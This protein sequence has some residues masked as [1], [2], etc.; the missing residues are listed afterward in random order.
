MEQIQNLE[1]IYNENPELDSLN[2]EY[3]S[4][5]DLT[6]L[7]PILSKFSE[8]K[9]LSL[10]GNRLKNLPQDISV[11]ENLE[12]LDLSSN[13]ISNY[14]NIVSSL[15]SLP[16]LANLNITL[17][18]QEDE[19]LFIQNLPNLYMLN[20]RPVRED[21]NQEQEEDGDEQ[22]QQ[23]QQ[24]QYN[25]GEQE[26]E[27]YNYE[28]QNQSQNQYGNYQQQQNES[29]NYQQQND[30]YYNQQQQQ[31]LK[32]QQQYQQVQQNQS[33]DNNEED[34][35]QYQNKGNQNQNQNN[36]NSQEITLKQED[37]ETVAI[38]YDSIRELYRETSSGN[39]KELA[40]QFDEHVKGVMTD[41]QSKLQEN[42]PDFQ[43]NHNVLKAKFALYEI[44]FSKT[45][46]LLN[47]VDPRIVEITQTLHDQH[48]G[49]FKDMSALIQNMENSNTNNNQ[50]VNQK[51]NDQQQQ[52]QLPQNLEH[53]RS[54]NQELREQIAQLEEENKKY[55][56]LIIKRSKQDNVKQQDLYSQLNSQQ[57]QQQ[58]SPS[59]NF[60]QPGFSNISNLMQSNLQQQQQYSSNSN[61]NMGHKSNQSGKSVQM[62]NSV[63]GP[64]QVRTLTLRQLKEIIEEIYNSKQK[65]DQKYLEAKLPRET[66]E[67][68]MYT[69][70]NQKY[71]LK[72]LIIEWA[73]AII[74]GIKKFSQEDNDI[75]VFGKILRNENDEEFRFVQSQVKN[76]IAELLKM[77]LRGKY[78]FKHNSEIKEMLMQKI[79]GWVFEE[80]ARDIIK[81]MYSAE[82]AEQLLL[83]L[84]GHYVIHNQKSREELRK[85]TR[86][87][88]L[89]LLQEKEKHKIQYFQFQKI[90]LD[91]QLKSHEKFLKKFIQLFRQL[92]VDHNGIINENEFR[93]L[94][95]TINSIIGQSQ[96]N[97]EQIQKYLNQVDPYNHQQITFS[98]CVTL[99]SSEVIQ[100][101]NGQLSILQ[102]L[103]M[104]GQNQGKVN[105]FQG[106]NE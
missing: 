15:Q 28:N 73:T 38:L 30:S 34:E 74:N 42:L 43:F 51:K 13:L 24:Q 14:E 49:I 88:Q 6:P 77:Y 52:Q 32:E 64:T 97:E 95:D 106:S 84:Q 72:G 59:R 68:H 102:C 100:G 44:C 31:Q 99:F 47:K 16:K 98:Q 105:H 92:D 82:D 53:W 79:N 71:G 63:V 12:F 50:K 41:L 45:I 21:Q 85:L 4:I 87:E 55:L 60:N 103:S 69:Y 81:Y 3:L 20:Q 40:T 90:I 46:N 61:S 89:A 10:C 22:L 23:Q 93:V 2:L 58:I 36:N 78:P 25:E 5:S 101:N 76:T 29:Q 75:A 67:Q 56:D 37:L 11:L 80:E 27:N 91:F 96:L 8:L 17:K 54:E 57:Q 66:M 104:D 26:D 9:V 1:E 39:D 35:N 62:Q 19:E 86:E 65:Y 48:F 33:Q 94:L 7:L 83:Q 18:S 70:L